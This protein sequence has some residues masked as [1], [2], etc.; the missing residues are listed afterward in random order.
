MDRAN[1]YLLQY[2]V[3]CQRADRAASPF[4]LAEMVR[5]GASICAG[6]GFSTIWWAAR[7]RSLTGLSI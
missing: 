1:D 4:P 7:E 6:Q 5:E 3:D 2:C